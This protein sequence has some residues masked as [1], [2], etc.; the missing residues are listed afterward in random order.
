MQVTEFS[1]GGYAVG[2][3][4][5][6]SL[7]DGSANYNF[8]HAWASKTVGKADEAVELVEPVHERGRLLVGCGQIEENL[9]RPGG[10]DKMMG[11]TAFDHL[12]QLIEQAVSMEQKPPCEHRFSEV[13]STNLEQL[14]FRTFSLGSAMVGKLKNKATTD[15]IGTC[16]SF[17]V[18][19]AHLWKVK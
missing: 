13:G 15:L 1:C 3:G 4:T 18:V 14:V 10:R 19:A 9:T 12:Y 2:V 17:E 11:V 7:F 6:H 16:S 8:M 5:N